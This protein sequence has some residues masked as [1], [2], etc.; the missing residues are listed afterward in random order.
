MN[1]IK[2]TLTHVRK[3]NKN[4]FFIGLI[5]I[6]SN[7]ASKYIDIGLSKTQEHA[8][9][10]TI[11][12]EIIIFSIVFIGTNDIIISILMTASFFILSN[13]L[14]HEESRFCIIPLS[15]SK[16]KKT[17]DT[18]KDNVI[19][20]EEEKKAISILTKAL[21]QNRYPRQ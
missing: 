14:F 15:M 11:G 20:L 8:L 6:I 19:S 9:R 17:I 2:K 12:R 7:I 16:I 5:M 18:N 1:L 4:K 13:H 21:N 3:L 10:N